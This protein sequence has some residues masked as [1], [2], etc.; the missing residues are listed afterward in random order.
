MTRSGSTRSQSHISYQVYF[1]RQI[2][3]GPRKPKR[4]SQ[5]HISYQVY[6]NNGQRMTMDW[7]RKKE[8]QSHISYQVY[9]NFLGQKMVYLL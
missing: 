6:F 4:L 7:T 2:C 5:S 9:F 1:N 3:K 8:S